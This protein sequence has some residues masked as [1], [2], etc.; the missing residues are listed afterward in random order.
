[1]LR[2]VL[3]VLLAHVVTSCIY[4][5]KEAATETKK[6][7]KPYSDFT[8]LDIRSM[9]MLC[10]V[11][12]R[13]LAPQIPPPVYTPICDCMMDTIRMTYTKSELERLSYE[14]MVAMNNK[15]K[16]EC[17]INASKSQL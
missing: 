10:S 2:I 3:I 9:W 11:N 5:P 13:R 4:L 15:F 16:E 14:E 8:T 7:E 1:M 17:K 6:V 12:F